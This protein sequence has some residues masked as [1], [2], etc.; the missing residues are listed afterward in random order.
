MNVYNL[1]SEITCTTQTHVYF[2][3]QSSST[4]ST[5]PTISIVMTSSNRRTQTY[6]TVL[7]IV[8]AVVSLNNS[9]LRLQLILVEDS[10]DPNEL[11][12]FSD[13]VA[14]LGVQHEID[15]LTISQDN[16]Q[17]TNPC[18]NYNIGF[19]LIR[20]SLVIV[21]NAEVCHV[22]NGVID[23]VFRSL[24]EK[25][26]VVFDVAASD[27][28]QNNAVLYSKQ[29]PLTMLSAQI[30][31]DDDDDHTKWMQKKGDVQYDRCYHFLCATTR[32]TLCPFNIEYKNEL[33]YDDDAWLLSAVARDVSIRRVGAEECGGSCGLHQYHI[34]S[35]HDE[36]E[37]TQN[38]AMHFFYSLFLFNTKN[39]Y[40]P[41]WSDLIPYA[42]EL[43][44]LPWSN[45]VFQEEQ[46]KEFRSK[47]FMS[48]PNK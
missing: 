34:R 33:N 35:V 1:L 43:Q 24:R 46:L 18:I 27:S 9:N 41:K 23:W 15:L 40:C 30:T 20:G 25:E 10:T 2:K 37:N 14:M 8:A 17:W 48:C 45:Q 6:F 16:K 26:H 39:V 42:R 32:N 5:A 7:S 31:N 44:R 4:T 36:Q 12:S 38:N 19:R 28:F 22:G 21:Q 29:L 47:I 3:R 13:L 11:L